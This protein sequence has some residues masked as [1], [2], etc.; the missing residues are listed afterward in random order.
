MNTFDSNFIEN[1]LIELKNEN[2]EIFKILKFIDNSNNI[3]NIN[4]INKLYINKDNA[5]DD[6]IL[7]RYNYLNSKILFPKLIPCLKEVL[8]N[9]V[10]EIKELIKKEIITSR[11]VQTKLIQ[12]QKTPIKITVFPEKYFN[13]NTIK[14][15]IKLL[16][17]NKNIDNIDI[18]KENQFIINND[19]FI[20]TI[21]GNFK[22][23]AINKYK[24]HLNGLKNLLNLLST[25]NIEGKGPKDKKQTRSQPNSPQRTVQ[26]TSPKANSQPTSP[27]RTVQL[28]S[29]RANASQN[30][31]SE[32][33]SNEISKVKKNEIISKLSTVDILKKFEAEYMNISIINTEEPSSIYTPLKIENQKIANNILNDINNFNDNFKAL[34]AD[35]MTIYTYYN[36]DLCNIPNINNIQEISKD[37]YEILYKLIILFIQNNNRF[38]TLKGKKDQ[39][40]ECFGFVQSQI[41]LLTNQLSA[42]SSSYKQINE[43][44]INIDNI[45]KNLKQLNDKYENEIQEY[46]LELTK[47]QNLKDNN[48]E[49]N[50][51]I[52]MENEDLKQQIEKNNKLLEDN[53]TQIQSLQEKYAEAE[54]LKI[55]YLGKNIQNEQALDLIKQEKKNLKNY[56]I[57]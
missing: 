13:Q 39:C 41:S 30:T 19:D 40:N 46:K 20:S 11:D 3:E 35:T 26:L 2:I 51:Q 47:I 18:F 21:D 49:L 27:Q 42:L 43:K 33:L 36:K 38:V 12:I 44:N 6:Y 37:C 23:A 17:E 1:K 45:N 8:T 5:L 22:I 29:P 28:T 56:M 48:K 34:K 7:L 32:I 16:I 25:T 14:D 31:R 52:N 10:K 55:E 24:E 54:K 57:N 53:K 9:K 15:N 4:D 50:N